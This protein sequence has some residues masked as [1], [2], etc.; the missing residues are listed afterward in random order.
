[1][2]V[3]G[4]CLLLSAVGLARAIAQYGEVG[5]LAY[6]KLLVGPFVVLIA[7]IYFSPSDVTLKRACIVVLSITIAV[8]AASS[9]FGVGWLVHQ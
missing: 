4:A 9:L 2:G 5:L 1:M 8:L 6:S 7:A 3:I